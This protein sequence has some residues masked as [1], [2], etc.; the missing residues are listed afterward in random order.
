MGNEARTG[1]RENMKT[2]SIR[3]QNPKRVAKLFGEV[4]G[5]YTPTECQW[6]VGTPQELWPAKEPARRVINARVVICGGGAHVAGRKLSMSVA[7]AWSRDVLATG[8]IVATFRNGYRADA[9]R[10]LAMSRFS[11]PSLPA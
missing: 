8:I 5:D 7:R 11:R 10:L 4:S 6:W 9:K 3:I 1:R 2:I